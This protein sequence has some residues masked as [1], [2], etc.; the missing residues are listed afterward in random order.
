MHRA[1]IVHTIRW[2]HCTQLRWIHAYDPGSALA[3]AGAEEIQRELGY[4]FVLDE[5]GFTPEITGDAIR[6]TLAVTNTGAAPFY[7]DW[8][9]EVSLLD[10]DTREVVW[11]DTF[12]SVDIRRW[13]GGSGWTL[14]QWEPVDYWAQFV[15]REGW[16]DA[17]PE[18]SAPPASHVVDETFRVDAPAGRYLLALSV[19]DPA[20]MVPSLRF[21]TQWYFDGGR[22]PVGVVSV[23]G[24]G[25]GAL[26]GET[27][28]DDPGQDTSLRYVR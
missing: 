26:P 24:G 18:W 21:A 1:F 17:P 5:V 15:V 3:Q 4:R 10:P 23:G 20:G 27:R 22:H 12:D 8:P 13:T 16:S 14:P 6:V 19:L 11:A 7:Y 2:L 9:L 25:G 28:F